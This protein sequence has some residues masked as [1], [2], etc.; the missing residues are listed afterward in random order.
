MIALVICLVAVPMLAVPAEAYGESISLRPSRGYVGEEVYIT[1][2][3]FSRFDDYWAYYETADGDWEMVLDENE[4]D[5]DTWDDLETDDFPIPE[6]AG[7]DHEI[8]VCDD[9]DPSDYV[10]RTDFTV[11]ARLE[12]TSPSKAE[13]IADDRVTLK[14]T[15]FAEDETDIEVRFYIDSSDYEIVASDI[16]ADEYGSWEITFEV[17]ASPKG[18]HRI[19]AEGDDTDLGDVEEVSFTM[20]SG[21]SLSESSGFVGDTITARGNGFGKNERDIKIT[22]DGEVVAED[23]EADEN[24]AWQESF[25]VPPSTKGYHEVDAY[26]S[27]TRDIAEK[28]FTVEPKMT[29]TPIEGH[30]GTIIEISGTGFGDGKQVIITYDGSEAATTTTDSQGSFPGVTFEATHIQTVHTV[31]HPVEATDAAGNSA[32]TDFIMESVAPPIPVLIKPADGS[33][34]GFV[35][36]VTP[37]FEWSAVTD[38]S[39][40]SYNLEI[41]TS[42]NFSEPLVAVT[43]LTGANYTLP[44]DEALAYGT[45]YWRVTAIDGARNDSGWTAPYSFRSG[46]FPF[47][48]SIAIIVL[49][50]AL[51]GFVVYVFAIR[52]RQYYY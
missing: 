46:F 50:V 25:T 28:D 17:P 3:N 15:G 51:I 21:L 45:Y 29:I 47:W 13:G 2:T 23:I 30:V 19:D 22:Y 42:E 49:I 38:P 4:I 40:V 9:D 5:V 10:A 36:K 6:S 11:E 20:E 41:A 26:G 24:G 12:I 33:R 14:G 31:D 48:A 43:G 34:S 1:G 39:G 44:G 27:K 16:E 7:G 52:R 37:A 8:R 32:I 18:K 35:G